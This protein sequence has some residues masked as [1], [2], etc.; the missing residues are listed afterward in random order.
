MENIENII[1]EISQRISKV[2]ELTPNKK[3]GFMLGNT[4]SIDPHAQAYTTPVRDCGDIIILGAIV[5]NQ[6]DAI[7][8]AKKFSAEV[9]KFFVDIEKKIPIDFEPNKNLASH[10]NINISDDNSPQFG[11][12][13]AAVRPYV[14]I[15]KFIGYKANDITVDAVWFFVSSFFGELSGKKL[16]IQGLG[17]IG[18]K[19]ALKFVESGMSV[20]IISNNFERDSQITMSLNRIKNKS[21]LANV[22]LVENKEF[23]L[24]NADLVILAT[25]VSGVFSKEDAKFSIKTSLVID[26]GKGNLSQDALIEFSRRSV[27]VWRADISEYLPVVISGFNRLSSYNNKN[28]GRNK[29][30]EYFVV[31]GGFIGKKYDLIVDNLHDPKFVYGVCDGVGGIIRNGDSKALELIKNFELNNMK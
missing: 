12:I 26:I 28:F 16:F 21:V 8:L 17:N 25:D 14:P 2:K 9:D 1:A 11:N 24:I 22:A 7:V 31:S 19:L 29:I 3:I 10:F 23:E 30:S 13:S 20:S 18:S 5:F 15:N 6:I 27:P 4:V